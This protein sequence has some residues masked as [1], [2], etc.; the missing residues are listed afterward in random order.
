MAAVGSPVNRLLLTSKRTKL[1][2][3]DNDGDKSPVNW[4][5]LKSSFCNLF[6]AESVAGKLPFSAFPRR[7]NSTT[8]PLTIFTPY[9]YFGSFSKSHFWLHVSPEVELKKLIK[10]FLSANEMLN[11]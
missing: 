10:A 1:V 6:N 3:E 5:E 9:Q 8:L 11:C 7:F 4:L 2:S